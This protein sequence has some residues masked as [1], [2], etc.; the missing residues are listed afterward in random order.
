MILLKKYIIIFIMLFFFIV[1]YL[2]YNMPDVRLR[3]PQMGFPS[4]PQ[5]DAWGHGITVIDVTAMPTESIASRV[6]RQLDEAFPNRLVGLTRPSP[7]RPG[8]YLPPPSPFSQKSG[9]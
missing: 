6:V 8:R 4:P 1:I 7:G 9:G 3:M 2:T 5:T